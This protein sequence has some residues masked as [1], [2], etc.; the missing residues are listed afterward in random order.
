[1]KANVIRLFEHIKLLQRGVELYQNGIDEQSDE[2]LP[3]GLGEGNV[4]IALAGATSAGKTTLIKRLLSDSAGRI[5]SKPETACLVIHTFAE[6]E[7]IVMRLKPEVSFDEN[8]GIAF[9]D[10]IKD[11]GLKDYY[12]RGSG[13][14]WRTT[15]QDE[16]TLEKSREEILDFFAQVNQFDGVFESI[17]WNH[18]QRGNDYNLTDLVDIYD[19]PGFG[20]KASHDKTVDSILGKGEFDILIYLID[21]S[22]GIPGQDEKNSLVAVQDYL[23]RNRRV[24][25]YWA[26]EKPSPET[27]DLNECRTNIA[28]AVKELGVDIEDETRLLDLR[29]PE[30]GGEDDEVQASILIDVLKPYFIA[31]GEEYKKRFGDSIPQ[32]EAMD[33]I[34]GKDNTDAWPVLEQALQ[35]LIMSKDGKLLMEALSASKAEAAILEEFGIKADDLQLGTTVFERL[36]GRIRV[37]TGMDDANFPDRDNALRKMRVRVEN[38]VRGIVAAL[39][40][41]GQVDPN[42][43]QRFKK[44]VYEKNGDIR[45][46]IFDTQFYLMLKNPDGVRDYF[47]KKVKDGLRENVE[48][49]IQA[50]SEFRLDDDE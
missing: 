1:M 42:K 34:F 26:Y 35:K 17:K 8:V 20:G 44:E 50:I 21:T 38:G 32:N 47:L 4:R 37:Q 16:V 22:K 31:L 27:L 19:L 11:F 36:M 13:F 29:G 33:K 30:N 25:F 10:F 45:T 43:V 5:S 41:K 7:N 6:V 9:R 23:S 18:K 14:S 39:T 12:A 2:K 15:S 49:E 3:R 40:T 24:A 46:F 48:K 28:N